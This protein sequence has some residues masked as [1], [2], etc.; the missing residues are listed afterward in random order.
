LN[1]A[2]H[3]RELRGFC[4]LCYNRGGRSSNRRSKRRWRGPSTWKQALSASA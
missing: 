1:P 2:V 4:F 3:F